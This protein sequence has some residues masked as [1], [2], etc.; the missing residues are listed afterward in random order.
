MLLVIIMFCF[1][2]G[3]IESNK[4]TIKFKLIASFIYFS[5]PIFIMLYSILI[6]NIGQ[7]LLYILV[8]ITISCFGYLLSKINGNIVKKVL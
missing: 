1:N 4:N 6:T 5:H 2:N 7:T 3:N 8:I